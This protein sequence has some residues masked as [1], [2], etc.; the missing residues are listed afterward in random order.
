M[1]QNESIDSRL[2]ALEHRIREQ[3]EEISLLVGTVQEQK[4]LLRERDVEL[5]GWK[6][7][8]AQLLETS[9]PDGSWVNTVWEEEKARKLAEKSPDGVLSKKGRW[10]WQ[11]SSVDRITRRGRRTLTA[12]DSPSTIAREHS[13]ASRSNFRS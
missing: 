12:L 13:R 4:G 3:R 10:E 11:V 1:T 8:V 9:R 5:E 2:S 6:G 7:E